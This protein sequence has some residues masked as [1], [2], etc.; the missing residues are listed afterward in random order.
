MTRLPKN[1]KIPLFS[2]LLVALLGFFPSPTVAGDSVQER[3]N[4]VSSTDHT[5]T[6]IEALVVG[7][8]TEKEGHLPSSF[9]SATEN[10][11]S[12]SMLAPFWFRLN[13]YDCTDLESTDGFN[14]EEAHRLVAIAHNNNVQ[15]LPV[16]HNFLYKDKSLTQDLVTEMLATPKSRNDCIGNIINL[17]GYYNFDGV[18]MDFEGIR[19]EDRDNLSLF[20]TELGDRLREE[21]YIFSAAIPA[22]DNDLHNPWAAPYDYEVIGEATDLVMLMMYNEHG[23]PGSGPGPISSIGFNSSVIN[24]AIDRIA[25]HKIIL[26]E[27]VF[28][29]DFNLRTGGY[30]YLSYELAME[31]LENYKAEAFFDP[32]SQTPFFRYIDAANQVH[33]VWYEDRL[34]LLSKL[35]LIGEHSLGGIALWR[36]GMEDPGAWQAIQEKIIVK[37]TYEKEMTTET[38]EPPGEQQ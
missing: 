6:P 17:L 8:Y 2:L 38:K 10:L 20:Y 9:V 36:L 23:F 37:H 32:K 13:Q 18:N 14:E 33:E 21:G 16:I 29:F 5:G 27:P 15:V 22:K 19:L 34:S 1:I 3:Y 24:Y 35:N 31:R 25:P 11:E 12:I 4:M 7:Y 30:A 28:G 26:A